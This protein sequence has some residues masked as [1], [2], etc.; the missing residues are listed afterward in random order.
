M[1]NIYEKRKEEILEE[2]EKLK[3]SRDLKDG[4]IKVNEQLYRYCLKLNK[5]YLNAQISFF[6]LLEE[7]TFDERSTIILIVKKMFEKYDI[8]SGNYI[9]IDVNEKYA[10]EYFERIDDFDFWELDFS[11]YYNTRFF[12]KFNSSFKKI[13]RGRIK[14]IFI[15]A[16]HN[17]INEYNEII[18]NEISIYKNIKYNFDYHF[19]ITSKDGIYKE[20]EAYLISKGYNCDFKKE[21]IKSIDDYRSNEIY[22][23][24]ALIKSNLCKENNYVTFK[25]ICL[26]N[27]NEFKENNI[28]LYDLIGLNKV[29]S[30][31]KEL[32]YLLKFNKDINNT[33]K[34]FLNS[35]FKGN[36]GTGKTT[37][38]R[39]YAK[40][41]KDLG[42]ITSDE[43]TEIVPNDLI[44][45]YVGQTRNTA[46]RVLEKSKGGILFIDEA[47]NLMEAKENSGGCYMREAVVELLKYMEDK[48]NV[49]IF[50]GYKKE[51]EDLIENINPG[52]KSRIGKVIDFDD[53]TIDELVEIFDLNLKKYNM[54]YSK[55]FKNG[56]IKYIEKNKQKKNFG[57]ARFIENL[58]SKVIQNHAKNVYE[59]NIELL[60]LEKI[61]L[62]EDN[63]ESK[64]F[65][66]C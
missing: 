11:D 35:I 54:N 9:R 36:P 24:T 6:Y 51:M 58:I 20:L 1:N 62:V 45:E 28:S 47:Y 14:C 48:S 13:C 65:G 60:R 40:L 52:F 23:E 39:C 30:E 37:V 56:L 42:Y 2:I 55:E 27:K 34:P 16:N 32:E 15:T 57:N 3:L 49:V 26:D 7:L 25:D 8:C 21:D 44:G 53:Y 31:I 19:N 63:V 46:R 43:I 38:A 22:I 64:D 12:I 10:R 18:E 61:D 5:D 59:N 4:L 41:L 17:T 29:K 33:N 66:F 50:A